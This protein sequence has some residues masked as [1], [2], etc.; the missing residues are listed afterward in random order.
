MIVV[1]IPHQGQTVG[2]LKYH[3]AMPA[4]F[5]EEDVLIAQLLIGPIA[6]GFS[7]IAEQDAQAASAELQKIVALKEQFVSTVSH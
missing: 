3:S 2:V 6:V 5:G 1:P 4:A 7:S